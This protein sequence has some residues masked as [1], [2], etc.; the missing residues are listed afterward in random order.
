MYVNYNFLINNNQF[1]LYTFNQS[2]FY[3]NNNANINL[4]KKNIKYNIINNYF[5][6]NI[7]TLDVTNSDYDCFTETIFNNY[8]KLLN[9]KYNC[10]KPFLE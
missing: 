10:Y 5:I 7:T 6:W 3:V 2:L 4:E 9:D 8:K 1:Y